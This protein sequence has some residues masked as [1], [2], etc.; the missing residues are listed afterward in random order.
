MKIIGLM[1]QDQDVTIVY[2]GTSPTD[3]EAALYDACGID[4][5]QGDAKPHWDHESSDPGAV[6]ASFKLTARTGQDDDT[7]QIHV[8]DGE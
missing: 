8:L 5:S 4:L 2:V 1:T 6:T 7:I 3:A